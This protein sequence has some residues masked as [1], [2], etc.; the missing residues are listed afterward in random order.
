MHQVRLNSGAELMAR[1]PDVVV[2]GVGSGAGGQEAASGVCWVGLGRIPSYGPIVAKRQ[3]PSA[4]SRFVEL[5]RG[6]GAC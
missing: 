5:E 3:N 1:M 4:N 6:R 2:W